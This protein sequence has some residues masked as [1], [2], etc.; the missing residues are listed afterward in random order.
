M[1]KFN[2]KLII[3]ITLFLSF[4]IIYRLITTGTT[5]D[6]DH[7]KRFTAYF[8]YEG[9]SLPKDNRIMKLISEKTGTIVKMSWLD[10]KN[11]KDSLSVMIAS[12]KY[13]DF[14]DG[15]DATA[16]LI[17]AGAFISLEER[18]IHY[19][20]LK[21]YLT[22]DEWN[23]MRSEDG[24]IYII[25]QFGVVQ[26]N[27][28]DT[29]H[30]EEAFFIQKAVLKWANYPTITTIEEYFSLLETYLISHP[31]TN[32]NPTIGFLILSDDWRDFCLTNPPQFLAGYPNDGCAIVDPSS[33]S[34]RLYD[35][36]PESKSYY[37]RLNQAYL[38]KVIPANTFVL[39]YPEYL[40]FISSGSV[41]GM[42]DQY[43]QFESAQ[44]H[45]YSMGLTEH[46]YVPLGLTISNDTIEHYRSKEAL[47]TSNGIG[48]SVDCTDIEGALSFLDAL[49]DPDMMKLRYW[50]EEGI[51]YQV[52][53]DGLFYRTNEQRLR[54]SNPEYFINNYCS[55]NFFPH[56]D[57]LLKD[58]MNTVRPNEQPGE[59][60]ASLDQ[61]DKDFLDA[62]GYETWVDFLRD[63]DEIN[64]PWF[65]LYTYT[66]SLSS[67]S[68]MGNIKHKIDQI[69]KEWIPKIIM[70]SKGAFDLNWSMYQE[71][72]TQQIDI[73]VYEKGLT[74]EVRTRCERKN[75]TY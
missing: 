61:Y 60:N 53:E 51:D 1:I 4:L 17:N 42:V 39:S 54:T 37:R 70:S 48:I 13:P 57:G 55:Y 19:P 65:P 68:K 38:N 31:E 2:K 47:D 35:F 64:P 30:R 50:G 23:K 72:F 45:L 21:N 15:S 34:A 75:R 49:L 40:A 5:T 56:Y 24:H 74:Q 66:N 58:G 11:V 26:G 46:T 36:I 8:A 14:I 6:Q 10:G 22:E 43:W 25:P 71:Y 62:Y 29:N 18:L 52:S 67:Q 9:N 63:P 27:E 44:E 41:L 32:G 16:D 33:L 73:T 59:F 7:T 20:N 28:T 69:R 12:R 3:T